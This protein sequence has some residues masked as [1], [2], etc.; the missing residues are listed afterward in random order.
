MS[1]LILTGPRFE[2]EARNLFARFT[3][4]PTSDR[5]RLINALIKT[6]KQCGAWAKLDVLYILAAADA[7]SSLLNWVATSFNLTAVASPTFAADRGYTGNGS[8][9]RLDT[10]FNPSTAGGKLSLNSVHLGLW[11]PGDAAGTSNLPV[12]NLNLTLRPYVGAATSVTAKAHEASSTTHTIPAAPHRHYMLNRTNSST[13]D[14]WAAGT[15]VINAA[16][17]ASSAM[18]SLDMPVLARQTAAGTYQ[19][20]PDQYAACH[21]GGGLTDGEALGMWQALSAYM[22]AVGNT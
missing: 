2:R 10:G 22:T 16:A 8:S 7:Q 19:Y 3:T 4:P 6:L 14:L 17:Q 20:A 21:W 15:K 13:Y 9:M 12:G 5:A 18:Q 11:R 1:D